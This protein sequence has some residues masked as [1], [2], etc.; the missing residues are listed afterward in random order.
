MSTQLS[1]DDVRERAF[2]YWCGNLVGEERSRIEE[3]L[4]EDEELATYFEKVRKVALASRD[5][6]ESWGAERS[7]AS[8]DKVAAAL[9]VLGDDALDSSGG[10]GVSM[11][12]AAALALCALGAGALYLAG[13]LGESTDRSTHVEAPVIAKESAP[14][15]LDIE[16][17]D[18]HVIDDPRVALFAARSTSWRY[19][20]SAGKIALDEGAVVIEFV[21]EH[22]GQRLFVETPDARVDVVG[23]VFSVSY[24]DGQTHVAVYE[25]AVEVFREQAHAEVRVS[26]G[27]RLG[28]DK[29]EPEALDSKHVEQIDG[30]IDL[31]RHRAKLEHVKPTPARAGDHAMKKTGRR[32]RGGEPGDRGARGGTERSVTTTPSL[33][34]TENSP[35][36][37]VSAPVVAK[38]APVVAKRAPEKA[39]E[40]VMAEGRSSRGYKRR[41]ERARSLERAGDYGEAVRQLV[42]LSD[43]VPSRGALARSIELDIA[44]IALHR[45]EDKPLAREHLQNVVE[46]WPE[47]PAA[48]LSRQQLCHLDDCV[49]E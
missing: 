1:R 25:G 42:L 12:V 17:L 23:T 44:R 30:L 37:V 32:G 47:H 2:A 24:L 36:V 26:S 34:V 43:D 21:P 8:W 33:T 41:L 4:I 10:G 5:A 14:A 20:A 39:R 46:R 13:G 28:A 18:E 45:L 15:A 22:A 9:D 38:R 3:A 29:N 19:E 16:Q 35:S 7:A 11:F 27:E 40:A 48:E 49:E 31:E 6:E